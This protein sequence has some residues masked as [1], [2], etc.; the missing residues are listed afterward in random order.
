M[1]KKGKIYMIG[2]AHLDPVWLWRYMEGCAEIKATFQS[3]LDRIEQ[4]GDFVFTSAC[5]A[6]YEWVE[7]NEPA[8]FAKVQA[9]VKAGKWSVAGG[10]WV[11]PDCNIPSGE[12][13]ARHMLIS[14]RYFKEKFGKTAVTGYNVDSFGHNASLPQILRKS[15][16][17]SYVY[18]R[19]DSHQEK[20]YPF[21]SNLFKW[22]SPDG[23]EV[24]AYRILGAYCMRLS[25]WDFETYENKA[26]EDGEDKMMFY[27]VGNHGGGPTVKMIETIGSRNKSSGDYEYIYAGPDEYFEYVKTQSYGLPVLTGD[28]QHHASGCYSANSMVKALNREAENRLV[29]AE[30]YNVL[31][32]RLLGLPYDNAKFNTAWKNVLFNQFHDIMCGCSIKEAYDDAREMYGE[33]LAIGSKTINA[34]IQ[35]ISWNVN[36]AKTV[37]YL[38]KDMDWGLWEQGG[39][40]TPIV[41]FNPLAWGVTVPVKINNNRISRVEGPDG[42]PVPV[43]VVRASQTNG[44]DGS[45]NSLFCAEAPPLGYTT[46]WA[47]FDGERLRGHNPLHIGYYNISNEFIE[48]KFDENTGDIESFKDKKTGR[49][50]V[51]GYAAKTVVIND[52]AQDT[53]SHGVF[54]FDKEEGAFSGPAFEIIERG[55]VKVTLRVTQT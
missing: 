7:E 45:F 13:F 31:A 21:K 9:A 11:Q 41:V 24:T 6:Y 16:I 42:S 30:K 4:F 51:S 49:E 27:G 55:A 15:G 20:K 52:A 8:M 26:A 1:G 50:F 17:D 14:Q 37:K 40:G 46:Y 10:M 44:Y 12:S 48:V 53:W 29:A 22:R 28:L 2:N 43:Q 19:P 5:A 33:S 47:Y 39:L 32:N 23:S 25:D 35:K 54:T 36:T 34:S 38:S 3:A 18:M